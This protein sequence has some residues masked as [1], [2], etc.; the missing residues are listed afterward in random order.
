MSQAFARLLEKAKANHCKTHPPDAIFIL[1]DTPEDVPRRVDVLIAAGNLTEADRPRCVFCDDEAIA[2]MTHEQTVD[3]LAINETAEDRRRFA[4]EA[5]A[6][7]RAEL[8]ECIATAENAKSDLPIACRSP[9]D[10]L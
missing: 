2:A 7:S 8:A 5:A 1:C 10:S 3:L 9:V 4:D 6:R